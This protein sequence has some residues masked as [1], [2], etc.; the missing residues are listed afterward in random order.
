MA[1]DTMKKRKQS[2]WVVIIC[3]IGG[4]EDRI[5]ETVKIDASSLRAAEAEVKRGWTAPFPWYMV[6]RRLLDDTDTDPREVLFYSHK[7]RPQKRAP[8]A[9]AQFHF[10]Q[11]QKSY[12]KW[13][14]EHGVAPATP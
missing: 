11:F 6:E 13:A 12:S 4:P 7:G 8:M 14:A 5:V 9:R 10:R 2:V 3:E 1:P